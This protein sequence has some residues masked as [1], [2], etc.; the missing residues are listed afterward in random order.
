MRPTISRWTVN[1]G[2]AVSRWTV[3]VGPAIIG[4]AGGL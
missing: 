2:P 3:N 1:V 4:P